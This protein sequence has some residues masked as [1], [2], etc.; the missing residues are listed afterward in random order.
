MKS[1]VF[2][3]SSVLGAAGLYAMNQMGNRDIERK[4]SIERIQTG[5]LEYK[6]PD[7]E[8]YYTVFPDLTK[9]DYNFTRRFN[10]FQTYMTHNYNKTHGSL[11]KEYDEQ[12]ELKPLFD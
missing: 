6:E 5:K 10:T 2:A 4:R 9:L 3:V 12:N 8:A 7:T 11:E 1:K